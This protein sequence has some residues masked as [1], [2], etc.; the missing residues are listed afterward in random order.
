MKE[1][2]S[3]PVAVESASRFATARRERF[4]LNEGDALVFRG[5]QAH[6]YRN[7]GGE[8]AVAHS[9]VVLASG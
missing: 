7:P 5:D 8:R 2:A 6:S 9:A 3:T 1:P 4:Q